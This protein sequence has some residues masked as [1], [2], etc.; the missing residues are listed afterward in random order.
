MARR[1]W[2]RCGKCSRKLNEKRF[3]KTS[4]KVCYNCHIKQLKE[5]RR[6]EI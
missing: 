5:K 6:A 4:T 3:A 1:N 2:T